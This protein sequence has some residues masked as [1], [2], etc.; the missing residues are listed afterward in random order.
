MT[1]LTVCYRKSPSINALRER[2]RGREREREKGE[3]AGRIIKGND[4]VVKSG[5][6]RV[7]ARE[8]KRETVINWEVC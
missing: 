1:A 6:G 4:G 3:G 2:E 8:G 7:K 5:K